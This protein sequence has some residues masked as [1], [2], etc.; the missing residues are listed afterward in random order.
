MNP[1]WWRQHAEHWR[2]IADACWSSYTILLAAEAPELVLCY[3]SSA[4]NTATKLAYDLERKA[5]ALE[6]Q[7][8][9]PRTER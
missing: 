1:A 8:A 2:T 5:L 3:A 9:A 7:A 4:A 6:A